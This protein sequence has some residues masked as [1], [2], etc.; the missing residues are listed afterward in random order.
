[1]PLLADY[2]LTPDVFDLTSYSSD[3]VC[4]LHLLALKE[5]LLTEGLVR[6][7]RDS[8]WR[9]LFSSDHRPWHPRG[10]ELVKKLAT[11][12]RLVCFG[13]TRAASPADDR[14]WCTEA[15]GTHAVHP[16]SGG[17]IVT[18]L[19]HAAFGAHPLVARIDRLGSA[20][21]WNARSPSVRLARTIIDY[22]THLAPVLRSA[23][24]IMF[25]DP[26]L[27]P[28]RYG[29]RE[30]KELLARAG[31]RTPAPR[32]EVHRVCYEGSGEGRR[33]LAAGEIEQRF[34]DELAARLR[35]A[36]LRVE[37]FVWDDFHDR[38]VISNIL[39]ILAAN[40]FDT[41]AAP[42]STTTWTRLGRGTRDDLQREFDPAGRRH[43]LRYRLSIP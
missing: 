14:E 22:Q 9:R 32:I 30:F 33:I 29:Y 20:P 5:V 24:S 2:A 6:D 31:G 12:G 25:I 34:R 26:H 18:E 13:P 16:F 1:M 40:G 43:T 10:K 35:G 36:G 11:Q 39:G 21:W 8:E 38:Y 41:T 27:D 19:V 7:L 28:T 15:L 3:E 17:I 42:E 4:L 23:H 37:L